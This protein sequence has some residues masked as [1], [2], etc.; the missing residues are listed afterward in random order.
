MI[1]G[2]GTLILVLVVC[3]ALVAGCG[4]R[5]QLDRPG[6]AASANPAVADP[7]VAAEQPVQAAKPQKTFI[8]DPLI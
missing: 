3:T 7:A 6:G 1:K 2:S 4:R 8:L 5:S